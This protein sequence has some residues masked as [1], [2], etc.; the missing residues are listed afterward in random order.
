[1][2]NEGKRCRARRGRKKCKE[3]EKQWEVLRRKDVKSGERQG[4]RKK[5]EE[6]EHRKRGRSRRTGKMK[7]QTKERM[8]LKA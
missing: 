7:S 5:R 4:T 2:D 1:M 3:E 8:G 6:E